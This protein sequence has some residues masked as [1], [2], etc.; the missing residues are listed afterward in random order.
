MG[1][2]DTEF[3]LFL[4]PPPS[5]GTVGVY[6]DRGMQCF[7]LNLGLAHARLPTGYTPRLQTHI[8]H[9]VCLLFVL[10]FDTGYLCIALLRAV[11][12]KAFPEAPTEK[13]QMLG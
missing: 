5:A 12:T 6:H 9:K 2:D 13:E 4:P 1:Q 11:L 10:F 8:L 3:L 7:E